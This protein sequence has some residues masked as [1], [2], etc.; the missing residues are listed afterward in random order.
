MMLNKLTLKQAI[1]QL[2]ARQ[3]S[4]DELYADV[5]TSLNHQNPTLNIYLTVNNQALQQAKV[6]AEKLLRGAPV[7]VKDNFLT[8]G[9]RTTAAA[10]LLDNYIP[11]HESTVTAR[12]QT[13]GGV[14]MGKTN[15]DAWAHGSST[16]TSQYGRTLNPRRRFVPGRF[17]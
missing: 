14:V 17:R 10:T 4:V 9:L 8:Q 15:L 7:A 1:D 12:L 2:T 6:S 16:E 11:Q 13:A 5:Q 3:I